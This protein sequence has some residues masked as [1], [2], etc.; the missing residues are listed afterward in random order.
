[1][2]KVISTFREDKKLQFFNLNLD[3][4][5][6]W[7]KMISQTRN[8]TEKNENKIKCKSTDIT[9]SFSKENKQKYINLIF[10]R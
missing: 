4:K 1:M 8:S 2:R 7:K 5:P 3:Y 9:K 6:P 10:Y